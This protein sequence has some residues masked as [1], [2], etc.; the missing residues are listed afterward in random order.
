MLSVIRDRRRSPVM[1]LR[2]TGVNPT[3]VK[4]YHFPKGSGHGTLYRIEGCS[5]D[6]VDRVLTAFE[7]AGYVFSVLR[8]D[9]FIVAPG[10]FLAP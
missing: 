6:Y 7:N 4:V 8:N 3:K 2:P 1:D 9:Y 5:S 10:H